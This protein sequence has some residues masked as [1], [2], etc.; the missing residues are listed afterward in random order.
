MQHQ[1]QR[2]DQEMVLLALDLVARIVPRRIDRRAFFT[3]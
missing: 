1:A 2:V 3:L